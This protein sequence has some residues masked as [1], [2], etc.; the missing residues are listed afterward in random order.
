ML[1]EL[2]CATLLTAPATTISHLRT[3][4]DQ[5]G[6]EGDL[7]VDAVFRLSQALVHN[8]QL[9]EA[10]RTVD[11]E[12]ARL[13]AG[14]AR[15]RLQAVHYM[16]QGIHAGEDHLPG[17]SRSLAELVKTCTGRD[18]SE[19][20]LL[21]LRGFDA[22]TRGESAE[23]VV[24]LCDR[25]LVNGRLAP[26]LGWTD[27]EW[28]IELLMM[29]G[30]SYAYADRLDRAES[31]FSE[32]LRSYTSAGWSGGHLA[33]A[34][35]FLG[36]AHRRRGRLRDAET[37]LRESLRIAERVG[38]GLPCTGPPPA[39]SSTH[40]S[41]AVTSRRPGRSPSSTASHRRTRPPS[42][43]PTPVPYADGCCSPSAASRTASTNSRPP[44][45]PPRRAAT[46]TR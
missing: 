36:L 3:A 46:T 33:L 4:L 31:L 13:D 1:Y 43:C 17:R 34:H 11:A 9:D 6:L 25:A 15:M 38:R 5:S 22:M 26:G 27:T 10:V 23:E 21:I 42:C 35:A 7:R 41:P 39:A 40:C 19:R 44:R 20:A 14:P 8:D 28:G 45:R 16:W 12:A 2:G 24:E 32:A 29:L 18:N 30:S 37:T